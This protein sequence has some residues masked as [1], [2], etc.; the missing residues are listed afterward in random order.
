MEAHQILE[1]VK[2]ELGNYSESCI[3]QIVKDPYNPITD[4]NIGFFNKTKGAYGAAQ[5]FIEFIEELENGEVD[6]EEGEM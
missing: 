4:L 1:K 2:K 3:A 5:Y 6:N